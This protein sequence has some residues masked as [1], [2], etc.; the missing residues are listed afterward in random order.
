[1]D[2]FNARLKHLTRWGTVKNSDLAAKFL[3]G[4]S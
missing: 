2:I 3:Q 4:L 1:M